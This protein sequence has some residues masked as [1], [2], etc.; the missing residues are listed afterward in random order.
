MRYF[1]ASNPS[2]G[3]GQNELV[4]QPL[5]R[6]LGLTLAASLGLMAAGCGSSSTTSASTTAPADPSPLYFSPTLGDDY[7]AAYAIDHTATP[8]PAF[9]RS[10][11]YTN[12]S[13]A[14]GLTV[15]DSGTFTTLSNG[16]L[17][18]DATYHNDLNGTTTVNPPPTSNWA[19]ELPGQA[20]LI[21]MESYP[22]F[23][24][25]V[26]TGSCPS[27]ATPET[28]LFVTIPNHLTITSTSIA[29]N[30]WNP[31]LETAFGTA[32]I[33]TNGTTV[34][35]SNVSQFTFPV[36]GAAPGA[37][38]N[39]GQASVAAACSSTFYGHT[40]GIPNSVTV[41][42]P[43]TGESVPPS[44][45]IGIGPA[46]F[47]VEDAGTSQIA[48]EPYENVLGAGYGA[49][50]LP[51]PGSVLSA[52]TLA[53]AQYQGFLYGSGGPVSLSQTGPGFSH[54]ASFG[55]SNLKTACPKLPT[56][57]TATIIYG[58]EFANNDPSSNAY[59]NCDMAFDLGTQDAKTNGLYPAAKVYITAS[60]PDNG[61]HSAYSF[62]AVAIAGQIGNK[63]AIFLIGVDTSGSP[64]QAW[65]IYL[66]QSN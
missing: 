47:L 7:Q 18:L 46:G 3:A 24:P 48:G 66:L 39:P 4:G 44:A 22:N 56:P 37:P 6:W 53:A 38:I 5:R 28:F 36:K 59:G 23:T 57:P 50:G 61:I 51:M 10:V 25:A 35:F 21:G 40:I 12:D 58:G 60:F 8:H 43:G 17:D 19:V 34:Q 20:A 55:Y 54:I 65:G 41:I 13:S 29:G 45:T 52:Q 42:N 26:P 9:T 49:I 1:E 62:P 63:Y 27:L 33:G 11:D 32:Q 2:V 16:I 15:T 31:L 14:D 30:R 64:S